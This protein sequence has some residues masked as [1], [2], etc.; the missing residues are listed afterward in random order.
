VKNVTKSSF[1]MKKLKT[2]TNH[3]VLFFHQEI[4]QTGK[5]LKPKLN[6]IKRGASG[7]NSTDGTLL[8]SLAINF[9]H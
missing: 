7:G 2:F 5:G 6:N 9:H 1:Q 8:M 4:P 3:L